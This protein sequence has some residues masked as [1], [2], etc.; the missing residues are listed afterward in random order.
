MAKVYF[1]RYKARID[2][3]EITAEEA[4]ALAREEV[5]ERWRAAVIDLLEEYEAPGRAEIEGSGRSDEE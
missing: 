2:A 3:G 1:R 5:P 4:I